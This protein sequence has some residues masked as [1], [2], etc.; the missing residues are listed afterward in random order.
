MSRPLVYRTIF[1]SVFFLPWC[2]D[3]TG[4][5]DPTDLQLSDDSY[6]GD[7]PSDCV[8]IPRSVIEILRDIVGK[9]EGYSDKRGGQKGSF[10]ERKSLEELRKCLRSLDE[11]AVVNEKLSKKL[12][13]RSV[14]QVSLGGKILPIT[15]K[16]DDSSKIREDERE[17]SEQ[18][19]KLSMGIPYIEVWEDDPQ[20]FEEVYVQ[21]CKIGEVVCFK[22]PWLESNRPIPQEVKDEILRVIREIYDIFKKCG[23]DEERLLG[24]G[25]LKDF[26]FISSAF[27]VKEERL[28]EL[29]GIDG[30]QLN[31]VIEHLKKC[32]GEE[33][34]D[35]V[36]FGQKVLEE[37]K[38]YYL[39]DAYIESSEMGIGG[40]D[41]EKN[42]E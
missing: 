38:G 6:S 36:Q 12:K 39:V 21:L 26:R 19:S 35:T 14:Q 29:P 2:C 34:K 23:E 17:G 15:G 40:M 30:E 7:I 22:F 1:W 28:K 25:K 33:I 41:D 13:M 31:F 5:V 20:G 27:F 32:F 3:G 18:E 37:M 8:Y 42:F 4:V 9:I 16:I 10:L 11:G 24:I